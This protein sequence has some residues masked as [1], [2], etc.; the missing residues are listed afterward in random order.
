MVII[1]EGI[2][3]HVVFLLQAP[4]ET[5][6]VLTIYVEGFDEASTGEDRVHQLVL[7]DERRHRQYVKAEFIDYIRGAPKV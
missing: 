7:F 3:V 2:I 5:A 6:Q 4:Q 1:V